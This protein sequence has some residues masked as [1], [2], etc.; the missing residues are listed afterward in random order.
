M[1]EVG[2]KAVKSQQP[3]VARM[4]RSGMREASPKVSDFASLHPSN[5]LE[6]AQLFRLWAIIPPIYPPW[7]DAV[8]SGPAVGLRPFCYNLWTTN[9]PEIDSW[10]SC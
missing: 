8:T 5:L 6:F 1:G 4:E 2:G 3:S 7:T 10:M 9:V